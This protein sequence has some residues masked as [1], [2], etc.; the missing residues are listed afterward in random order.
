MTNKKY[1]TSIGYSDMREKVN[2]LKEE[3][4]N[5][6]EE[7]QEVKNNCLSTDDSSELNQYRL[8]LEN[9]N[10]KIDELN[11]YMDSAIVIDISNITTEKVVFGSLVDIENVDTLERKTYRIVSGFES[12]PNKGMVSIDSP[13]G[14]ALVGCV[15]GD[16]I[17]YDAPNGK[18][19]EFEILEIRK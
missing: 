11:N 3:Y 6:M 4:K 2:K 13:I 15:E 12:D 14:K 7:M 18:A 1:I 9:F 10:D 16:I 19:L 17:S 5:C 8:S